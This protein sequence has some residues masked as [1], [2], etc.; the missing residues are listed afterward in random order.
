[1]S[2]FYKTEFKT[3]TLCTY[4]TEEKCGV[5]DP[6]LVPSGITTVMTDPVYVSA[7]THTQKAYLTPNDLSGTSAFEMVLSETGKLSASP[8]TD[9][10]QTLWQDPACM[11][12][13]QLEKEGQVTQATAP[14]QFGGFVV[15]GTV[16]FDL[17][18]FTL[19]DGSCG[20]TLTEMK[21]CHADWNNCP[22]ADD[23]ERQAQQV[24]IQ[25]YF[26][27]YVN[28]GAMTAADIPNLQALAWQ[29]SYE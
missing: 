27:A 4:G 3:I 23:T 6:N 11:S 12:Y 29:V 10:G 8:V 5:G 7:N 17:A 18:V 1:M 22:G 25:D 9:N 19:L 24:S 16:T 15:S 13:I 2:G 14:S 21:N 26:S 28:A 20:A